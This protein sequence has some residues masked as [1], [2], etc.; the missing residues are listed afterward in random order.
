MFDIIGFTNLLKQKGSEDLYQ[1]YSRTIVPML[2]HAAMPISVINEVNGVKVLMPDPISQRVNF[3]FFSDTIIFFSKDESLESFINIVFTSLEL[4]K[5]G[6]IGSKAPYRGAI[7]YGDIVTDPAGILLGTSLIDAYKGEQSQ[8]W[9]GCILTEACEEFC[10]KNNY[11]DK[12]YKYFDGL[13]DGESDENIQLV[14]KKAKNTLVKYLVPKQMKGNDKPI[15]YFQKEHYVLDWTH[16]V[17]VDASIKSFN[18]SEIPHQLMIR[19]NTI[20]FENWA[21]KKQLK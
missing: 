3:L 6:F 10:L 14:Y 12:F 4:L 20:D 2:Q 1:F 11:I 9:S 5:S 7:G 13:L 19:N 16:N 8:M 18:Q 15:E 17:Y 21:R